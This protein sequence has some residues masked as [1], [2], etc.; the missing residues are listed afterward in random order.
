MAIRYLNQKNTGG[1]DGSTSSTGYPSLA[2]AINASATGDV[3]NVVQ[4]SG[5]YNELFKLNTSKD[6]ITWNFNGEVVFS[7]VDSNKLV[8]SGIC[9]WVQSTNVLYPGY[10]Y[11]IN[12]VEIPTNLVVNGDMETPGNW[13]NYA[14]GMIYNERSTSNTYSGT[15]SRYCKVS[16]AGGIQQVINRTVIGTVYRV[17]GKYF[18]VGAS[19]LIVYFMGMNLGTLTTRGSWQ[20]F[21]FDVTAN[22]TSSALNLYNSGPSE[23]YVDDIKIQPITGSSGSDVATSL[24]PFLNIFKD[25]AT[26]SVA[27]ATVDEV[28]TAATVKSWA[29]NKWDWGDF[30]SLGFS[31][32]YCFLSSGNPTGIGAKIIIPTRDVSMQI[33]VGA[34]GHTFNNIEING[35][36]T[37]N[38]NV[39]EAAIFNHP[40]FKR[41]DQQGVNLG[42]TTGG[43]LNGTAFNQPVFI[44]CGHRSIVQTLTGTGI[45]INGGHHENVHL[46]YKADGLSNLGITIKNNSSNNLL[47]G[48]FQLNNLISPTIVEDHN[49]FHI[50]MSPWNVQ[51]GKAI[52]YLGSGT[53]N[54]STTASTDLPASFD[55]TTPAALS[56]PNSYGVDSIQVSS[57]DYHLQ[58]T[59]PCIG[60]GT[61]IAG[62]TTDIEGN[63]R[64]P[65]YNIGPFGLADGALGVAPVANDGS[66][67]NNITRLTGTA[68]TINPTDTYQL[69]DTNAC[70]I[71]T[72]WVAGTAN[73]AFDAN[74]APISFT[75]QQL[76]D[77]GVGP[78]LY[79]GSK[80]VAG[81]VVDQDAP[82]NAKIIKVLK[83]PTYI[84]TLYYSDYQEMDWSANNE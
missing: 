77:A 56:T 60:A 10:F 16:S 71:V 72:E 17:S 37:Q 5:P 79:C 8:S 41:A 76:I 38:V 58:P 7:E 49:Q 18:L 80:G 66:P 48:A 65:P 30:D 44:D 35:G 12:S 36:N 73:F 78:R 23:F 20:S 31:T 50:N 3:I 82:T 1:C 52:S 74:G 51:G 67:K 68:T 59:S 9:K 81:Y 29:S 47:A 55:A 15:Y 28:H 53:R 64:Y 54:W 34:T 25:V 4:G 27:N 40:I 63:Q 61:A 32:F 83:V 24:N 2:S 84:D 46:I 39:A 69:E 42:Y 26:T 43:S 70:R 57:T 33:P 22:A 19:S 6:N 14:G 62:I 11:L 21:S 45:V 13:D 75:G